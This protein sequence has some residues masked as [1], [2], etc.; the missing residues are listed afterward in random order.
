MLL[1]E[2]YL[3]VYVVDLGGGGG[4]GLE[5]GGG[6][7]GRVGV[8]VGLEGVVLVKEVAVLAVDEV[9][10]E[11]DAVPAGAEGLVTVDGLAEAVEV[12]FLAAALDATVLDGVPILILLHPTKAS[13][14]TVPAVGRLSGERYLHPA[15]ARGPMLVSLPST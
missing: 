12:V 5:G 7:A 11:K 3:G 13:D 6:G 15:K 4:A 9:V 10:L 1:V 2:V 8:G 14:A